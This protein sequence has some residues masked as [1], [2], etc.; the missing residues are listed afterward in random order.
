MSSTTSE[1]AWRAAVSALLDGEE[2]A[3]DVAELMAHL[4]ACPACSVWLDG[5]AEVNTRLRRLPVVEP[6][7]GDDVVNRVDVHLCA[8][9]T[10]G[11]CRCHDCQCGP[12]CTC[13]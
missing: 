6:K 9:R 13:H 12:G 10:G 11:P 1:E 2:P 7:L 8:C 4:D 5:A 3:V